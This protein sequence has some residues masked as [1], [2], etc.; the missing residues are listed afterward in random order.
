MHDPANGLRRIPILRTPVNRQRRRAGAISSPCPKTLG[1]AQAQAFLHSHPRARGLDHYFW[2]MPTFHFVP[3]ICPPP[4]ERVRH[5]RI[6][7]DQLG[8]GYLQ[9]PYSSSVLLP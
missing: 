1:S 7:A 2:I 5:C 8:I 6:Q 3:G 4:A 9:R